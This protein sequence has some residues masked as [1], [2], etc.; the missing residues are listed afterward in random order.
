MKE[1]KMFVGYLRDYV[2]FDIETTGL[3]PETDAVIEL[4]ALRVRGGEVAEE[5]SS[6][7][8]PGVH[9]PYFASEI[10]GITD[11]MVK[12]APRMKQV[13]KSFT[14]F[15]ADDVLVGHNIRRFDLPF[16]QRDMQNFFGKPLANDYVDT[17]VVAKRYL[18]D[19]ESRSLESLSYYY[20]V[21]YAGAHRALADCYINKKIYD[22]LGEEIAN[23]SEA[24]KKLKVCPKCGNLMKRRNGKFGEFWGCKSYPD[25]KY[26]EDC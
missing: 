10:N 26:T 20:H 1:S 6:L 17:L 18:P 21:S 4:S 8:N 19:L 11:D 2:L 23:P 5:F 22:H 3:S 25:C 13:L 15:A 9:I 7:V 24:V 16:I 12:D 14:D